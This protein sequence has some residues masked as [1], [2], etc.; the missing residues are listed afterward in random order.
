MRFKSSSVS[1]FSVAFVS[2]ALAGCASGPM[3]N[4]GGQHAGPQGGHH[5]GPHGSQHG[6][7]RGAAMGTMGMGNK[8]MMS[9]CP[10]HEQMTGSK[11]PEERKA[12]MAEQ[13]KKMSPEMRQRHVQTMQE[14][15]KMMQEVMATLPAPNK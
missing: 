3:A 15:L 10:M 5:A 2:L 8:D 9:M 6:G 7:H 11:T 13:M 14:H 12:M 1:L 4:H